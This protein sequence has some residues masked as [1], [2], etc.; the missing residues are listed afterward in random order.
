[1]IKRTVPESEARQLLATPSFDLGTRIN[2]PVV[3]DR[4]SR[5][6]RFRPEATGLDQVRSLQ[7]HVPLKGK[8]GFDLGGPQ[9][10]DTLGHPFK[11]RSG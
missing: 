9:L 1:M 10:R 5:R 3:F 7:S 8:L 4:V 2:W 6:G 11:S